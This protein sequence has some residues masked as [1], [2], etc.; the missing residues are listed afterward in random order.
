MRDLKSGAI[1]RDQ[2]LDSFEFLKEKAFNMG[3]VL[4]AP[5]VESVNQL[6]Q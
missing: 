3:I 1:E 5:F 4:S 2:G 6:L